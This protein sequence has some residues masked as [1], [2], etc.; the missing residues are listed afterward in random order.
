MVNFFLIFR[1]IEKM[2]DNIKYSSINRKTK[3]LTFQYCFVPFLT[4]EI[5][6]LSALLIMYDFGIENHFMNN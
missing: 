3:I 5:V 4:D 2:L 1:R 6:K